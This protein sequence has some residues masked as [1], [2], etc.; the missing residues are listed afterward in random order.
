MY[1]RRQLHVWV[2]EADYRHLRERAYI[3]KES[4]SALVRQCIRHDRH[5]RSMHAAPSTSPAQALRSLGRGPA[6]HTS[7]QSV[8]GALLR[9]SQP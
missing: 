9:T 4:L 5:R 2:S 7:D 6:G 3:T 1:Q 8:C